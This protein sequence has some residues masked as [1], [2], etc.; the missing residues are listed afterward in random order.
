MVQ[1]TRSLRVGSSIHHHP[2]D[3]VPGR[4]LPGLSARNQGAGVRG[5]AGSYCLD[6]DRRDSRDQ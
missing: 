4:R 2:S 6:C 1:I 3:P 5:D